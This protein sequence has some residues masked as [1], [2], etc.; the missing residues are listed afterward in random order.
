MHLSLSCPV[1]RL[2]RVA[3]LAALLLA[4][5]GPDKPVSQ[6]PTTESTAR[7]EA[8][9]PSSV[10]QANA[11][12]YRDAPALALVFSG[13]L[14]PKANW[15]SWLSV[16]EGGKQVQGEWI[17]AD[18]G[19]TLYFP[20]VQPDKS[21][22]VSLKAGLGPSPLRWTL[23]TRPLET[24]AS[25]T[26]SGMVLPLRDELR[27][28]ISAVNVD[29]VNIDF[30]RV[31]AEY[32][33]RFLAE[34]RP[35]AGMGNWELEQITQRAKRVFSGRYALE[36]DANRRETRLI[37][38]KEPQ[39]AEAGVY[40]AV[41]SPL[42]NYD[43]RKETTYFAVSDMGLSAR[44]YRD[45]LEVFVSSLASADPL[46]DVQ[47]SLLDQKGNRLQVQTTD[48]QG[49]RRFDQVQGARL[50]LAE[51]GKHLAV[52][53][54]DG[55]ALDLSTFDLGTQP[56]QAQQLYLFSGRDLYR[57]GE[58]LDS[59]ILL[60]GQDGQLLPGMAVELEVKQPDGQ[61][62][63]QKRLLPD[64][65]GAAHYGLHLP[66]DAPLGRWT[67][68]LK[69]AAGSRFEWPFL[70]EE[71]LPERLK[72]QLG[73]GPDGEV[74]S[75][76]AALTLPL[77][78]DYLYGAP[79][80]A[81]KAKAEVKISR[82]TM[83]FTQW[84]EFTLG[85]VLLAE[86]A[87]DLEPLNLTLDAQGQ[88][89]FSLADELDGVRA[90][91]PLEVAYRVSLA[92]PGGRAVNRSRTQYGWPAGSQWPALKADFVADRVEGGKPLP[93]Q[94][95]NLDEQGQPVAG[96]VKVRLIN[97]YRDYYW[98]YADGEGWK[99]EFNSQP[100]LEQEQTLQLDGKGPTP[101]TLQLA[102]GWYRLEVENSQGHQSS[103]RVEIGSYAW[104]GGG[105]QA[106]PDKIAITLD[107]RAYQ[108]GEK[109]KVTLVAPRP[110]KGLLLVE[111]GDGL[112]WW[113]RIELKGA[114]G[115]AKDAR[116]EFEIPVS[117]EW[118]RHDLHISAQ[119]A[120]PDS[121]SK[122]VSQKS[123]Q[124]LRSV[125]L[126]PLT[127]DRE[128]RRLPLTL[129]APDKAVP[130]TRL[131]VTATSTPNSQGRVVLAAVDR[132]VLNISDYQPLDPFEIFFGRKRFAQDLFDNYGQVIP[133]QDGKLARL[134][135]GGDRAPLKKGGAL[136]SR[137]E[138]AALW[139]G[140]VSFDE[141]G[142][143][144]IPLE[145][146]NFNGEL[147]LMALA[148]NEQQVGEAE[149]A[150]KVVAP[151]VA[152]IG[153]PRFGTRGDETRAL[154]QLRNMSGEDQ[155]LSLAWTLNGGLKANGELPGT[156]SLK[157]GEEQWL[158]LP[159]TVTGASGVASLQLAASGKDFAISRDWTLPL[160]SPWP[161]ETRQR[162][163]MLAPGQEMA[164]APAE[165][166]GLDRANLQGLLSLSGTPPW[167]PAAQWQ[168]L[169]DYP[170]ACLEQ[171][172]SRAWPYLLTTADERT[173]WR[174]PAEGKKAASEADV[175]RALLQRLQ[176]LQLPS[177]GF[178]L[179]DGRSDE[180]QWL[181]AYAADYLLARKEAG[182]AVPEAMLNQALNRLQSYLTDSQ[183]GERWSSAPEHSRLAYQTYSAYVLA[184]VGKAPLATLR[185]IWE[186]QADH[187]RSGLP[188]LHLSLALSAMGD[189]QNAAKALSRALATERGD[190]Y[191][192]DYGSPLRDQ[193]LELSLLRQ[194]KLA[195]ERWPALSA[196]VAD[197]LAHR[198]WLSTQER[199]ALLRL[200]RI[201]PAVDWQA[202]VASSLGSGSLSGLAPLQLG[203]PEA[204]A[205][206]AV[207]NEGK[208][209]LY[210][211]RTLIG[212]PEQA[213]TRLSQGIS[214][215]RSWF[216]SD[217][218]P[219][220]PT[221]VKVGDLV[222][223]RLNVSSESAVPD[224]LLVEMV[225]AG[226]ELENPALGNSIKLDELSIEGKPAW[227]SEWNDYLKHQ[228]FRDDR[229]TAAM[230]LSAGS[231]QQLVY[232]MRA[233]TPGRYQVP[234]TQVEDMYR[235][236]LRAVGEDI[237][238][239][240]IS[241]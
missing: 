87:K 121:D 168:A 47:L 110:G 131:E 196:K 224:A 116:G 107:K 223:V 230:D 51:Q 105:E 24:G 44:R 25:F 42:G 190:D 174:K 56:W 7:Q 11:R 195:A 123:V 238:E 127:L 113:Q 172:L 55:A 48:P 78:G 106:R 194:H 129:S 81:T 219:F 237:H 180:E 163:Q 90:L 212:Y 40:F 43:W 99:Y 102:A 198:Q 197:T 140:E 206:S 97:E 135:Y 61:L 218:Q 74:T 9:E 82:A 177:G 109:A 57:P 5:C 213:P 23:K 17:L 70:V 203:A 240:H 147:A 93:F 29:E 59:E 229:Y 2:P 150:V 143:A 13:P 166:A 239:V 37:N 153:W 234:P 53:R 225:P 173:A 217:G 215:T 68:S 76:D 91:G 77:Q 170:Y 128:A 79:A 221:K 75:L 139:S 28:P 65:L 30:F 226:F 73:K 64:N 181:T 83:P 199:L 50:L 171:T 36:L 92:E 132:G 125:G 46:K 101:L 159:L 12:Q 8:G 233:V 108:A 209:S 22:E 149:R 63:E 38:V 137:V 119:I 20:N 158:T 235:P 200:A 112:R 176:R 134:N 154:V 227:Q 71:F 232:L 67:I 167:D 201:D 62:L 18:D 169:A 89:T 191:L 133:P 60:K 124:S 178:G 148:W 31:D 114:G 69:T 3:W 14:A 10:V 192:G 85:D 162:Y 208:G 182:D 45:E 104:G 186:Q 27:L 39:L 16:S 19:R 138:I 126:V 115:D 72:L 84:Q 165:L 156:L 214:V 118:L 187:A 184:R 80:S 130:L 35:G 146:P 26:A 236:E 6:V 157:N 193:A 1:T 141:S 66:D 220:D 155:T 241:E 49:H 88:G 33:P 231:N 207:T 117:P 145:L 160:R 161:A 21:Y 151:L 185:L 4:G 122:P 222:V 32:L 152:E 211:Q 144:V 94:I 58:R 189:E 120:A 136:E 96:A 202:W 164:F 188:L 100:Y 111:D 34:Y 142:K 175:Q 179:W 183:Y 205:A 98:H 204:L 216:N 210:V 52:L 86:Q 228:E 95:L 54:L 15:Q 41:M 103:L